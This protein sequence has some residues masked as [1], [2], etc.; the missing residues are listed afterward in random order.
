M[1]VLLRVDA[2]A[3]TPA[4]VLRPWEERDIEPLIEVY[5]DPVIQRWTRIPVSH[6]EDAVRWLRIQSEGWA[7]GTRLSFAVYEEIP[8]AGG[9]LVANIVVKA[10][11]P[12]GRTA[13]VGYW[14]AAAAR[15]RGVAPRAL[16]AV[17]VWAFNAVGGG[18]LGE[19]RLLHQ[20]DNPASCRVAEKTGYEYAETLAARP[21][22]PVAG[23]LH[24]RR[25]RVLEKPCGAAPLDR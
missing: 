4:M 5:R 14:T 15:G 16:E 25:A 7:D 8:A 11:D 1:T 20:I 9:S 2:T 19:L 13:E 12:A 18:G 21:P 3:T 22:F 10:S 17:S 24:I 6:H 23:H